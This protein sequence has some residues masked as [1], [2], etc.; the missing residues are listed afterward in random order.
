MIKTSIK[1]DM[2]CLLVTKDSLMRG[3]SDGY[4]NYTEIESVINVLTEVDK[5]I[6]RI[7]K[8][9]KAQQESSDPETSLDNSM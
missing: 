7:Y 1:F 8:A 4:F 5:A 3:L 9:I 6:D 2:G